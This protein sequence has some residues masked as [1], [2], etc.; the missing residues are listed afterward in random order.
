MSWDIYLFRLINGWAGRF[1]G[2]DAL[3]VFVAVFLLPILGFLLILAAFTIKRLREEHWYELPLHAI[4]ATLL[5]YGLRF[6]IG[7]GFE[8]ARPFVALENVNQLVPMEPL[9][10]SFPS[11]HASLAFAVAFTVF[12]H[13][14]D[15]GIAFLILA[16]LT[17]VG[18][19]FVGVHY[20]LD[21]GGGFLAGWL[22]AWSVH[23][24]EKREW[25]KIE[26]AVRVR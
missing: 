15:W 8:R 23:W 3:G 25:S 12:K 11:G 1:G 9:Y 21:V 22:S 18:R 19:I 5:A 26:R 24:F 2:L 4:V 10:N 14:R 17:A 7:L 20:P 6:F 16:A 13:D